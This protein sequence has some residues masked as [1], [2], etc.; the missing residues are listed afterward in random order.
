MDIEK[1]HANNGSIHIKGTG[2]KFKKKYKMNIAR[3]ACPDG[4][5]SL[6]AG[7]TLS[8]VMGRLLLVTAFNTAI[9]MISNTNP[10]IILCL[11]QI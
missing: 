4:N 11:T 5:E 6:L 10:G 1:D 8:L 3:A 2:H 7:M 9:K